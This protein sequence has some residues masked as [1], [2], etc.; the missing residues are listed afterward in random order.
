MSKERFNSDIPKDK[1]E[2]KPGR[3]NNQY[4]GAPYIINELNE[5]CGQGRWGFEVVTGPDV[6]C[7]DL[8]PGGS[9]K[10]YH[11][12]ARCTGKLWVSWAEGEETQ[13]TVFVDAGC[14]RGI[15]AER[16]QAH[17]VAIKGCATDALKRCAKMLGRHFGVDI[18]DDAKSGNRDRGNSSNQG[19]SRD[20]A[21]PAPE[22]KRAI[23]VERSKDSAKDI[24]YSLDFTPTQKATVIDRIKAMGINNTDFLCEFWN[25]CE[26]VPT[27]N[28]FYDY[29]KAAEKPYGYLAKMGFVG[30]DV[31]NILA[32]L[33]GIT[34]PD[35]EG[36]LVSPGDFIVAYYEG[37]DPKPD[38]KAFAEL[39]TSLES[40]V[41]T[42]E[43]DEFD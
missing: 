29:L 5:I 14:I 3:G 28:E 20:S 8:L 23:D 17:I 27:K 32:R 38:M 31:A 4:I 11:V 13:E 16:P 34:P 15:D 1:L 10:N 26:F 43:P 19:G 41:T 35:A 6:I 33:D 7:E 42:E 36:N 40:G 22:R 18:K 12:V 24:L 2:V 25:S 9:G 30:Q 39:V 21:S 37:A